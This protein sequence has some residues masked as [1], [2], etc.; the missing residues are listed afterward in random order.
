M[1]MLASPDFGQAQA[2]APRAQSDFARPKESHRLRNCTR[3]GFPHARSFTAEAD[4]ARAEAE[5]ARASGQD[6]LYGG[7]ENRSTRTFAL[8]SPIEGMWGATSIRDRSCGPICSSQFPAMFVITDPSRLWVQL[9]AT[10]SQL[11]A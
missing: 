2:D 9:D 10:E 4:Y 7:G 3:P 11:R 8:A 6:R 5:L 1:A